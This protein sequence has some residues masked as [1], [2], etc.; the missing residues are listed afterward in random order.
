MVVEAF[1]KAS[2]ELKEYIGRVLITLS[3]PEYDPLSDLIK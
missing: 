3:E 1:L 2:E